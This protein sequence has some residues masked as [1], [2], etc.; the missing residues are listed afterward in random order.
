[1]FGTSNPNLQPSDRAPLAPPAYLAR[2]CDVLHLVRE[3]T[4][5]RWRGKSLSILAIERNGF[6]YGVAQLL[7][8]SLF[9]SAVAPAINQTR[10]TADKTLVFL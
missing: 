10:T 1:M 4:A 6:L 3:V 7:K 8:D 9:I 2:L 5:R